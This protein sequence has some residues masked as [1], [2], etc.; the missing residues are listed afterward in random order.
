[1]LKEFQ[2]QLE[3][4]G[5]A[6][7]LRVLWAREKKPLYAPLRPRAAIFADDKGGLWLKLDVYV[8]TSTSEHSFAVKHGWACRKTCVVPIANLD[9]KDAIEVQGRIMAAFYPVGPDKFEFAANDTE[10]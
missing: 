10:E 6:A 9:A 3:G 5:F 2:D 7:R 4:L 8:A 1:M